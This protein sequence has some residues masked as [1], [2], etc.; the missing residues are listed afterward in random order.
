MAS[1]RQ[2]RLP[3]AASIT[4]EPTTRDEA[5]YQRMRR[6]GRFA[7][8]HTARGTVPTGFRNGLPEPVHYA[9]R[10]TGVDVLLGSYGDPRLDKPDDD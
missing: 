10:G 8:G 5:A 9:Y 2:P 6:A 7:P 4:L 3:L 1:F